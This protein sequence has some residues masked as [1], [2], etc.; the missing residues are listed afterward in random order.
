MFHRHT[1]EAAGKILAVKELVAV[2]NVSADAVM[3]KTEMRRRRK[4][5]LGFQVANRMKSEER[6]GML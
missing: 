2:E 1:P 5:P 3:D 4:A 6:F